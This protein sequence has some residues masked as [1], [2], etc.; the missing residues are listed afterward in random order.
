M[1]TMK[2]MFCCLLALVMVFTMVACGKEAPAAD[3]PSANDD[4][5]AADQ[6]VD[7][8]GRE[9][10]ELVAYN[11]VSGVGPG[12]EETM[13]AVNEYL[14]EKLNT[15]IDMHFY[16]APDYSSTVG[17]VLSSGNYVDFVFTRST[18]VPFLQ[19]ANMNAFVPLNDYIDEYLPGTK[20]ALP[21]AS[22]DAVT[23]DGQIY[24]VP[25]QRDA[26][27]RYD[28]TINTTMVEDLG[29]DMPE[30]FDTY[31]DLT[32]F[33]YEAKAAR[34]AKYPEKAGIPI[35]NT[36]LEYYQS[37]YYCEPILISQDWILAA[38]VPGLKGTAGMGEGETVF[39]PYLTEE[40]RELCKWRNQLV[41]DG[42]IPYEDRYTYDADRVLQSAGE[43]L[44]ECNSGNVYV[45]EDANAPYYKS[46]LVTADH[47]VLATNGYQHGYAISTQ[48]KHIERSLEVIDL[49]NTDPYL[50]TLIRFGPEG[51]GWTDED[52]DNVIELPDINADPTN[53]YW[54]HWYGWNLGGLTI[55]KTPPSS[56]ANFGELLAEL[57]GSA[58]P[59]ANIGFI[60]DTK[61]IENELAACM[62]VITEY[63][64]TLKWGQIDNVDEYVD[65][66]VQKL[67]DNGIEK[68]I[69]EGQSQL[70]AW[71]EA[72]NK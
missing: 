41:K 64:G 22:W 45:D 14:K 51:V 54:Y 49:F 1:L 8:N 24:A 38:N 57:N 58:V 69:A 34:D 25:L 47:A 26:A 67:K 11:Y 19:Y 23:V 28:I 62:N 9:Y 27:T 60:M 32:D 2:R 72:N 42:I 5:P 71:R 55:S 15:T 53:R 17:T 7:S 6:N 44:F 12:M 68:I 4:A 66:F 36:L 59:G 18:M 30:S 3:A 52:N 48:S 37:Y 13:E 35:V 20:A 33:M 63:D 40:Y 43:F 65:E 21:E 50:A 29:I 16:N 46:K 10:V 31:Y 61:P 70:D 39:S 56:A